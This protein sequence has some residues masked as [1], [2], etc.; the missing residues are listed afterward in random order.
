MAGC[1]VI[2]APQQPS[3]NSTTSEQGAQGSS[4]VI[5]D[6]I[7]L[8][9]L[10]QNPELNG[11][12]GIVMGYHRNGRQ[13]IVRQGAEAVFGRPTGGLFDEL[14]VRLDR[15]FLS[16]ATSTSMVSVAAEK[17]RRI[18]ASSSSDD[19]SHNTGSGADINSDSAAAATFDFVMT[20]T[21]TMSAEGIA[22]AV[23]CLPLLEVLDATGCNATFAPLL[24]AAADAAS[25]AA[26][27]R[28]CVA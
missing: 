4:I 2:R 10:T 7:Q 11:R 28:V 13:G 26:T 18:S 16:L 9:S 22:H 3:P 8:H 12:Q 6:R 27:R 5:G 17:C 25:V 23:R 1:P 20:S 14:S 21:K 19:G 24:R 15:N